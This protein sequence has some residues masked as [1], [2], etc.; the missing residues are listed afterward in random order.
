LQHIS[1]AVTRHIA[2]KSTTQNLSVEKAI[3]AA[4][5]WHQQQLAAMAKDSELAKA[6]I[7]EHNAKLG[8][9]EHP[10]G[11]T[12][13]D[14]T[15]GMNPDDVAYGLSIDTAT[16]DHCVGQG[17]YDNDVRTPLIQLGSKQRLHPDNSY[18]KE[19]LSGDSNIT[20]FRDKNGNTL[21]TIQHTPEDHLDSMPEDVLKAISEHIKETPRYRGR[22]FARVWSEAADD[23]GII[24]SDVA[25]PMITQISGPN[26]GHVPIEAREAV[27]NFLNSRPW[28]DNSVPLGNTGLIKD[29]GVFVPREPPTPVGPTEDVPFAAGGQVRKAA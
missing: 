28:A 9:I 19:V 22:P 16:A 6:N 21:A 5:D 7:I 8:G 14:Y 1:D 4:H 10:N 12:Q 15:K 24:P 13:Y 29:N 3:R 17:S 27:Q 20:S 11:I 18:V 25:K 2:D 26:N 23:L